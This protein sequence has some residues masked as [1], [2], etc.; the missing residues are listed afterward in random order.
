MLVVDDDNLTGEQI[1]NANLVLWG[2]PASNSV[3][4]KLSSK[5][6]LGWTADTAPVFIYPNPLNS[7]KYVVV[8]SG[9]T[10]HDF[11]SGSNAFHTPKLPDWATVS[12]ADGS[13]KDVGFFDEN[14][15]K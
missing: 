3:I 8:N 7:S 14:W 6:P 2:D 4:G 11:L 13:V 1:H 5:L 10:W 9:F 15:K 12:V